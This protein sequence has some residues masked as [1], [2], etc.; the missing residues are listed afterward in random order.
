MRVRLITCLVFLGFAFSDATAQGLRKSSVSSSPLDGRWDV[1]F[2][3][4]EQ[5]YR[6]LMEFSV[7]TD[8]KVSPTNL[9]YP[10]LKLTEGSPER[11]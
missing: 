2:D 9:G 10:L 6:T 4:P 5:Q 11:K 8:G 7:S 3:I 1:T